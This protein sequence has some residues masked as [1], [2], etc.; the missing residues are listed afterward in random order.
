[1]K[2]NTTSLRQGR[3]EMVD[4]LVVA[5]WP[6]RIGL[7]DKAKT[8][9]NRVFLDGSTVHTFYTKGHGFFIYDPS[10]K[11]VTTGKTRDDALIAMVK[12]REN[13][14]PRDF[15]PTGE[16]RIAEDASDSGQ[17]RLFAAE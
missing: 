11:L 17:Q 16:G 3:D 5:G 6:R 1:M 15:G 13:A 8:C 9:H 10:L 2:A 7:N 4:R 12:A 14:Q